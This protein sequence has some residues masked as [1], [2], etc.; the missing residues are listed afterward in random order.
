MTRCVVSSSLLLNRDRGCVVI[1]RW[2]AHFHGDINFR[3]SLYGYTM[4]FGN[5]NSNIWLGLFALSA[6]CHPKWKSCGETFNFGCVGILET[7]TDNGKFQ[8]YFYLTVGRRSNDFLMNMTTT[9]VD[10]VQKRCS[11]VTPFQTPRL[12]IYDSNDA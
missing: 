8:S 6:L 9:I 4:N 7:T 2:E 12:K 3:R 10:I 5:I 1:L 11:F